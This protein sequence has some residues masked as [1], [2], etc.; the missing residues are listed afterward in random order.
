MHTFYPTQDWTLAQKRA[1]ILRAKKRCDRWWVD[2]LDCRKSA[3]RQHIDMPFEEILGKLDE[4]VHFTIVHRMNLP[5]ED[6]LEISFCTFG[7]PSYFLWIK[8]DIRHLEE[9]LGVKNE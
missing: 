4:K 8:L 2:I 3:L 7:E 1:A 5:I 6:N 9:V